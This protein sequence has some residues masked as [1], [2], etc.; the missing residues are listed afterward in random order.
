MKTL[1]L[2]L[3]AVFAAAFALAATSAGRAKPKQSAAPQ[4]SNDLVMRGV[5]HVDCNPNVTCSR[6][7]QGVRLAP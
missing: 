6:S 7:L 5:Y 1:K 2:A 3:A 4:K